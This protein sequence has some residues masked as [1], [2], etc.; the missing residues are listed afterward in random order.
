MKRNATK[1]LEISLLLTIAIGIISSIIFLSVKSA[2]KIPEQQRDFLYLQE[3][4]LSE[5]FSRFV[6]IEGI[7]I[8]VIQGNIVV[9]FKNNNYE[10]EAIYNSNYELISKEITDTEFCKT[11]AGMATVFLIGGIVLPFGVWVAFSL[12]ISGI[13]DYVRLAKNRR[14]KL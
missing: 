6:E 2:E 11:P 13:I 14:N 7:N 3:S 10:L 9:T 12:I 4:K 1:I 5:D 8:E